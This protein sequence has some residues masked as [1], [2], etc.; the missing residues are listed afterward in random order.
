MVKIKQIKECN[1]CKFVKGVVKLADKFDIPED[2]EG[3]DDM[4]RYLPC[5][6]RCSNNKPPE[7]SEEEDEESEE[8]E[9]E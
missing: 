7:E 3:L 9:S 6:V 4:L 5:D 1:V 2:A 8:E